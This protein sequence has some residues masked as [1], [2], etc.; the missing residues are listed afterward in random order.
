MNGSRPTPSRPAE[1]S[2]L[3]A[4]SRTIE[5]LE[6]RIEGLMGTA[7]RDPRQAH[8]VQTLAPTAER[9]PPPQRQ[10]PRETYAARE[11]RA[12]TMARPDPLAEIRQR[13]RALETSRERQPLQNERIERPAAAMQQPRERLEP[14]ERLADPRAIE[15]RTEARPQ[16]PQPRAEARPLPRAE[17][18]P[19]AEY[20]TEA[21][22]RTAAPIV[23]SAPAVAEPAPPTDTAMRDIAQAL[24]SLRHDLKQDISEGVAREI[25]ELRGE[26]RSIKTIAEDQKFAEDVRQDLARL[27]DSISLL[28]QQATT[29]E[30]EGLRE[31]FEELRSL[32]DGLAREESMQRMESRWTGVE[33]RLDGFDSDGVQNELVSLA[34]RLDEMK[35]QLGAMTDSPAIQALEG[36]LIAVAAAIE[37][38]GRHM[39]PNDAAIAGQFAG[40]D[41]RLDEIS[42]AITASTAARAAAPA[43][44]Q[45]FLQR[46]ED[47]I[48]GLS[49]QIETMTS[50]A[51]SVGQ[52]D[53]TEEL[54]GRI[55]LLTSRIEDLVN[56][57]STARLDERLDQLSMLMERSAKAPMQPEL[58]GYLSDISRKIDALDQGSL[59]EALADR[60][61]DLARRI[62]VIDAQPQAPAFDTE[63]FLRLEDRLGDIAARLDETTA[64]PPA[65]HEAL[66]GLEDQIAHLSALISEPRAASAGFSPEYENRMS[67]LEDY[68]AT[69][70]EYIIEA[71]RQAAEAV[72]EAY[73]RNGGMQGAAPADLAA[74]SAL[75]DDLRNLEDLSRSSEAR[76]QQTFEV[77][78]GTLVQIAGRLDHMDSR[79]GRDRDEARMPRATQ[80]VFEASDDYADYDMAEETTAHARQSAAAVQAPAMAAQARGAVAYEELP[81]DLT[82]ADPIEAETPATALATD[83]KKADG[84]PGLLSGLGKRFKP[85]QKDASAKPRDVIEPTPSIDPVDMLD[86]DDANELLEPGSGAPDV[87]KILERVRAS[88]NLARDQQSKVSDADRADYIAAAR[89]AA[90]A[91]AQEVDNSRL[92]PNIA[93]GSASKGLGA[94]LAKY[95]RPIM[96]AIGA[97]LLAMMAM[98]LIN[99][100]RGG[101]DTSAPAVDSIAP[102]P[103]QIAPPAPL[104]PQSMN[105]TPAPGETTAQVTPAPIQGNVAGTPT[106]VEQ[107]IAQTPAQAPTPAPS[108]MTPAIGELKQTTDIAPAA[109]APAAIAVPATIEPKSL[110]D[111]AAS[112]DA[113]ALF[114]LGARYT[115]GRGVTANLSEAANWYRLSAERGFAP[116]QYRLAN[117]FEKGTGVDR[118]LNRAMQYYRQSATAGNAS[119]MHNLAVLYASGAAGAPDY[120]SA[121]DWFIKA[122]DRGVSDS[123]FNLAILYA[124]GNGVAQNLE[125]SYKWFAIAAKDGDKDAAQKRDEV[126]NAMKPEQLQAARAKVDLWKAT[127]LD[128]KANAVTLPDEW[129]GNG[130]KTA[131]VDMSKAIRNIQAILNNNG[132]DAGTP[133]GQ[134]GKKTVTAIQ[135]FQKSVGQ[136]PNGKITDELVKELLARNK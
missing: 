44:D 48:G 55:E 29:P 36:K 112:G 95:R 35:T 130:V 9:A 124:R 127:P 89:R 65:D 6:A 45:I 3:D 68:M 13:Q 53:P 83:G 104:A 64:A 91:A 78:H 133:D 62:E 107:V 109:V 22:A 24:V 14:R 1:R 99:T 42:R 113:L 43:A 93:A 82:Y 25:N 108:I 114:E 73:S 10:A 51:M 103:A 47:R 115:E 17:P 57:Q 116:A 72:A 30:A 11:P 135:N 131:T 4:L 41:S 60:L 98:P 31:E 12:E 69:S 75:A 88:Q 34:Y 90:Q 46:L 80:P 66:R 97:A 101:V 111:A 61:E 23:P 121:V 128:D 21:R 16:A 70:D 71:A 81:D 94:T 26:I 8:P 86:T 79:F 125:E 40:L 122:A 67:A 19:V 132:Y 38:I 126:A 18:R 58:T 76:T 63:A 27:A 129:A 37:Q 136:E 56:E 7:A 59:N 49:E 33:T 52:Y 106:S 5:G 123:Q 74:L 120:K 50:A 105:Q 96:I 87:K 102:A 117:L 54:S 118:D 84:K 134:M 2:S 85:G 77:L 92:S 20:R 39:Q 32:M 15:P 28:G 100:L 110:A 119:S